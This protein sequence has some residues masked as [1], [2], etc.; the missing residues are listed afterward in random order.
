MEISSDGGPEF[1]V[2][3]TQDFL[4]L[5]SVRHR[6]C[7][8][9]FPQSNSRAEVAVKTAKRLLVSNIGPTDSL[10]YDRFLPAILQLRNT[11]DP[12]CNLSH[13]QIIFER[14]LRDSL[15]FVNRLEKFSNPH[16]RLLWCQAWAAKEEA[17]RTRITCTTE[18]L[19]VH[20]RPLCS[21]SLG[22][23][24]FLSES[25]RREPLQMGPITGGS[26]ISWP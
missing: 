22:E 18:C 5:W 15:S 20:S 10:H 6:A 7:S 26:G 21:L 17:L 4:R 13:A 9:S 24:I 23:R 25:V 8:L 1:N 16:I 11:P 3:G 19:K 14:A 2:K 12:D